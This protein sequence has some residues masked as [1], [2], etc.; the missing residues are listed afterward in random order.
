[1][2]EQ[3]AHTPPPCKATPRA[4]ETTIPSLALHGA[5]LDGEA[6]AG[7]DLIQPFSVGLCLRAQESLKF[8]L[9]FRCAN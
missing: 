3:P 9:K 6:R 4:K 7:K 8:I 2:E 1:M 5:S